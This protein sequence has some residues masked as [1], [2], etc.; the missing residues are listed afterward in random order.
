MK[1]DER[2]HPSG[3]EDF[4]LIVRVI[5]TILGTPATTQCGIFRISICYIRTKILSVVLHGCETWSITL[6]EGHRMKVFEN[7]ALRKTLGLK[8]GEETRGWRRMHSEG[9]YDRYCRVTSQAFQ[10]HLSGY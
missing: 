1:Y 10:G 7:R 4:N 9:L 3:Y 2:S 5:L 8:I 6:N